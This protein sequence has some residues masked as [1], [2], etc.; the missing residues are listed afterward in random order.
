MPL[1]TTTDDSYWP[2]TQWELLGDLSSHA[3]EIARRRALEKLC[4][5]YDRPILAYLVHIGFSQHDA[6]DV[7]Q[8]FFADVVLKRDLLGRARQ[9]RGRLRDWIRRSLRNYD[10]N[11]WRN[12]G[13]AKRDGAWQRE[14]C[15]EICAAEIA[16]GAIAPRVETPEEVFAREWG[17]NVIERAH[18]RLDE[19]Y[20]RK[21]QSVLCETLKPHLVR[22]AAPPSQE[23]VA[24]ALGISAT[25]LSS[26]LTRLRIR[27]RHVLL[28]LL[29]E[30][31]GSPQDAEHAMNDL[32]RA[33]AR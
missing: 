15:E 27:F 25:S 7:R 33:V 13:A 16:V 21:E 3:Q 1:R 11:I 22:W 9:S 5:A 30:E 29:S 4:A 10:S 12:R 17:R 8:G 18:T 2:T 28:L 6:E 20:A 23:E 32:L 24:R 26:E 31:G 14:G 19:E